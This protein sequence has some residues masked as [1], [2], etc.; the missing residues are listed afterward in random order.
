M[1]L[2]N[3]ADAH[4]SYCTNIHPGEDWPA[5]F[6]S[7]QDNIPAVKQQVSPDALFGIGLRLSAQAV[8]QLQED[9]TALNAFKLWLEEQQSYVFTINGFPYGTFHDDVVK[10]NVYLPDWSSPERLRYTCELAEVLAELLPEGGTGSIS[11]VPI[12]FRPH[13][14]NDDKKLR[15][16]VA[17]LMA[18]VAHARAIEARTG[19]RIQ[20]ALEPEPACYLESQND[21]LSFFKQQVYTPDTYGVLDDALEKKQLSFDSLAALDPHS[22]ASGQRDTISRYLGVCLDTCHCAV[23]FEDASA[24]ARAWLAEQIPIHKVQLT[25]ALQVLDWQAQYASVLAPYAEGTYL[26]QTSIYNAQRGD[27]RFHLDLQA[28]IEDI[29]EGESLCSHF[30][31]PV[32]IEAMQD[33]STTQASLKQFIEFCQ[34]TQVSQHF[35]VETYTF[36]VLPSSLQKGSV[37]ENICRELQWVKALLL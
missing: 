32:F 21:V 30:H 33:M 37:I 4:L 5:V 16:A 3:I 34:T 15:A 22:K 14:V 7:L 28:A 27:T 10:E 31:V 20:L 12:G 19:R 11:T 23:M 6:E 29:A 35:E 36:S 13:F 1:R 2:K 24:V 26:H 25:A 8:D 18:F 17:N 9:D